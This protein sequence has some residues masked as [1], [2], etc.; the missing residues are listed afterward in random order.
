MITADGISTSQQFDN[1]DKDSEPYSMLVVFIKPPPILLREQ[2][3]FNRK[4]G[5]QGEPNLAKI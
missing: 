2:D 1:A 5:T 4:F 3:L